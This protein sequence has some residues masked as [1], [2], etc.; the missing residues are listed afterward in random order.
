MVAY[1]NNLSFWEAEA[2]G[3]KSGGWPKLHS[4]SLLGK[5]KKTEAFLY[6]SLWV[7]KLLS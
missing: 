1:T 7:Q 5:K 6:M 2:G 4:E 3:L